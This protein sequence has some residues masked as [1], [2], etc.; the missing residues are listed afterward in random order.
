MKFMKELK[1]MKKGAMIIDVS[2]DRNGGIETSIP[3]S[4]KHPTY[5]VDGIVHKFWLRNFQ[6]ALESQRRFMEIKFLYSAME[7]N[8]VIDSMTGLYNRNGFNM[9][10]K[11]LLDD[12]VAEKR[13]FA[14]IMADLNCLKYIN[15]VFGHY[16]G[17]DA[18]CTAGKAISYSTCPKALKERNFRMGGDEYLKIIVGDISG[19]DVEEC[20]KE[21][22]KFM[23]S[24]ICLSFERFEYYRKGNS[25]LL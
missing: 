13:K 15:D 8:A 25:L 21:V 22:N 4:I 16:A 24:K 14:V 17:D 23:K 7:K 3:T 2:C 12:A 11:E 6:L 9:Y 1:K 10:S 19:E 5:I 20:I 18:I